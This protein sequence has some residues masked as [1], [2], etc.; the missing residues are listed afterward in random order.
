M[1]ITLEMEVNDAEEACVILAAHS[2]KILVDIAAQM[3]DDIQN[4]NERQYDAQQESLMES[5]GLDDSAYR[6]DMKDAG[7]GLL[8]R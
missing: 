8:L 2:N 3:Q 5:G 7:R 4:E 6:R 1:T